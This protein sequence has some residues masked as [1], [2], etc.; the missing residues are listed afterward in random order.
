MICDALRTLV[1]FVQFKKLGKLS[2]RPFTFNKVTT[3]LNVKL[4]HECFSLF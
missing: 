4:L 2:W 1:P 3:L